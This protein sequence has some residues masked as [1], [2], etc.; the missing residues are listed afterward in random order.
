MWLITSTKSRAN[1]Q[2]HTHTHTHAG[3]HTAQDRPQWRHLLRSFF[4]RFSY[5]WVADLLY[6]RLY[7]CVC[8]CVYVWLYVCVW[9]CLLTSLTNC[10]ITRNSI[11]NLNSVRASSKAPKSRQPKYAQMPNKTGCC[12]CR[13]FVA[14]VVA[15]QQINHFAN[16]TTK[17][18]VNKA[19]NEPIMYKA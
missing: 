19:R 3:T 11:K 14:V 15:S 13:C 17:V 6:V 18:L 12:C 9:L 16:G 2:S 5:L 8:D 10:Q 4:C 7:V 1:T